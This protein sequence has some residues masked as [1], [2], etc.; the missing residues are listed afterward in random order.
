[1]NS[2]DL[3][4]ERSIPTDR[5]PRI[6]QVSANFCGM[7]GVALSEQ[8]SSRPYSRI[9]SFFFQVAPQLYSRG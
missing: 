6:D 9:S 8:R 1:M 3:V 5:A 4:R 7:E 2:V